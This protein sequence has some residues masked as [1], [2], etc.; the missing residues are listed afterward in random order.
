M[1]HKLKALLFERKIPQYKLAEQLNL[2][3]R[4]F[5]DKIRGK[6]EFTFSEVRD[7]CEILSID[8]PLK[9]FLPAKRKNEMR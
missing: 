2:S 7:I 5:S 9:V 4:T 1:Q 6:T 8:N 3:P